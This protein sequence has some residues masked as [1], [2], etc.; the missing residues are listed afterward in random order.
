MVSASYRVSL[1]PSRVREFDVVPCAS[2]EGGGELAGP[3][4]NKPREEKEPRAGRASGCPLTRAGAV[5]KRLSC[6]PLLAH[7]QHGDND[8]PLPFVSEVKQ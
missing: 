1:A 6:R 4:E 3:L 7:A 8:T 5:G 2:G